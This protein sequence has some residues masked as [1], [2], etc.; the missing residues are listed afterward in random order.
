MQPVF[1]IYNVADALTRD[2]VSNGEVGMSH[3]ACC[4]QS[5]DFPNLLGSQLGLAMPLTDWE[6]LGLQ[7]RVVGCSLRH[8]AFVDHI[9]DVVS[10]CPDE[11]MVRTNTRSVV[12]LV[13]Y[14][15]PAWDRAACQFP[16]DVMGAS[17]TAVDRDESIAPVCGT[18]PYPT[19]SEV[20]DVS[21]HGAVTVDFGPKAL[22]ERKPRS[23][24]SVGILV[25]H[26]ESFPLGVRPPAAPPVR[27]LLHVHF[28][29]LGRQSESKRKLAGVR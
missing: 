6:Q 19:R 22:G 5:P 4:V 15:E 21:R 17:G 23:G 26:R 1:A 29:T 14:P 8:S 2:T 24:R 28:T 7:P 10:A 20:R 12:T 18:G 11:Q 25:G 9:V 16:S 27:G 3:A 13:E